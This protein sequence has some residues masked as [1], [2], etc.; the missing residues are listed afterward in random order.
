[1][2][3]GIRNIRLVN[4]LKGEKYV[5]CSQFDAFRSC[6]MIDYVCKPGILIHV[7]IRMMAFFLQFFFRIEYVF[8]NCFNRK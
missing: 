4:V 5:V 7:Y 3:V 1:M 2:S 6:E 8:N